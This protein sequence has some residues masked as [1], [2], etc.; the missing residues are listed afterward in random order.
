MPMSTSLQMHL[1]SRWS[2]LAVSHILT[3]EESTKRS[4]STPVVA[5]IVTL[6]P[7]S[8]AS[9]EVDHSVH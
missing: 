2:L 7:D 4:G 5:V 3:H 8:L 9:G 1:Y 6:E